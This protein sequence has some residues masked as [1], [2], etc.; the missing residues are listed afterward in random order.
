[1]KVMAIA[2]YDGLK[3]LMISLG[4][5]DDF[6]LQVEVGD[7]QNGVVLAK[8]AVNNGADIIISRGG[9][10]E[11]IQKEVP[12]PVIEIEVSGYD[13]LRV[14]TLVKDYPGKTAIVG[15]APISEGAATICEILDIDISSFKV[16]QEEE[17]EPT[18]ADLQKEGYQMIIGDV[19][20]VKK[21]E[22]L[23]LNGILLTSGKES[24]LKSFQNAKK[25]HYFFSALKNKYLISHNILQEEKEGIIVYNQTFQSIFSNPYFNE[26][27]NK[28]F[29]DNIHI[30]DAVNEVLHKGIFKT[31]FNEENLFWKVTGSPLQK[32]DSRLVVFRI[33][34]CKSN[35]THHMQG[36]SIVSSSTEN[37]S[38]NIVNGMM[39]KNEKMKSV[40]ETAEA[41]RDREAPVWIS[42][43]EGTG[44]EKLVHF[45]HF[46]GVKRS[47]PLLVM[48]CEAIS[49]AQWADLLHAEQKENLLSYNETGTVFFKNIDCLNI[50]IQ[51]KL[52]D[53]LSKSSL[54]CRFIS[55]SREDIQVLIKKGLFNQ[56]LYYLLARLTLH[57]PSL[58]ERKEDIESL[59]L[60]FINEFNTKYGKQI[61]GIRNDARKDLENFEWTGNINQLK[62][63]M[64]ESI[65]LADGPYLEK[66]DV[67][68][69][70]KMKRPRAEKG[71]VDL[72]GT[73]E[74]IEQRII[75]KVWEEEG[76]NHT[77]TAE[78]LGINR[79]T[80][81]R[82]LK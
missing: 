82:K 24:V 31:F 26:K 32:D 40:L 20:T 37:S 36:I 38:L 74:E 76:M 42:G 30:K 62:Q 59:A 79:T 15:F 47:Y 5:N 63:V 10:A 66:D 44:K 1:M 69:V 73:L 65:L 56:D 19:I 72:T 33:Q 80:L 58:F 34:T 60:L 11:L 16:A 75:R 18:L 48:D 28:T 52:M 17:V 23:G 50:S 14:L 71:D 81:W 7:L 61:V 77:R 45:I 55:S 29:E 25:M 78:R 9:T 43:E 54:R 64:E 12:I 13:M 41:Y 39:T 68:K 8:N 53:Y 51:K 27:I 4:K 6:E 46:S 67:K 3:E 2:P 70:L 22:K 35:E 49:E 21:A 57:L